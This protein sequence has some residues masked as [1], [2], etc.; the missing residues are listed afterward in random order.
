MLSPVQLLLFPP[1]FHGLRITPGGEKYLYLILLLIREKATERAAQDR[2]IEKLQRRC[3]FFLH[4]AQTLKNVC[5]D[6]L[7]TK[8]EIVTQ[9]HNLLFVL[10]S[11]LHNLTDISVHLLTKELTI[12]LRP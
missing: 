12:F 2:P 6:S 8:A 11:V 3:I 5:V 1:F 10:G 7:L 9:L 4:S